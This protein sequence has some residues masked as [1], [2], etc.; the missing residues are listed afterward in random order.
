MAHMRHP[1]AVY[2]AV[3][4]FRQAS[5]LDNPWECL[6]TYVPCSCCGDSSLL[7]TIPKT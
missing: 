4:E 2:N 3:F 5:T 6:N 1:I 7:G